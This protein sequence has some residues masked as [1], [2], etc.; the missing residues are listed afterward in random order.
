MSAFIGVLIAFLVSSNIFLWINLW[1][2]K[3]TLFE[4]HKNTLDLLKELA[5][6]ATNT[7]DGKAKQ[8][9]IAVSIS[10]YNRA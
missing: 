9:N 4:F 10:N 1:N 3:C 5:Q 6:G 7:P 8:I 2:L